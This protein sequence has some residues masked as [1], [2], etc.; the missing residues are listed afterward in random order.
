MAWKSFPGPGKTVHSKTIFLIHILEKYK[1]NFGTRLFMRDIPC[2]ARYPFFT[3]CLAYPTVLCFWCVFSIYLLL[4][5]L[6][7]V[8]VF[9]RKTQYFSVLVQNIKSTKSDLNSPAVPL[10]TTRLR[11]M[12]TGCSE[13]PHQKFPTTSVYKALQCSSFMQLIMIKS[14]QV[15]R[16]ILAQ[17]IVLTSEAS[18]IFR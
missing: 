11:T 9:K 13:V 8:Q 15:K 16:H 12:L 6:S 14:N 17:V 18:S 5:F 7:S 10:T 4:Q 1:S 3:S 2:N